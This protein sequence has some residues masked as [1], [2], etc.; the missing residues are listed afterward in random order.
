M[1]VLKGLVKIRLLLV[2]K[3]TI[4]DVIPPFQIIVNI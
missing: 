2:K 4:Y 1:G 3:R